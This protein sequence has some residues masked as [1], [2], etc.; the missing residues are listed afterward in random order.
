MTLQSGMPIT[1]TQSTNNNSSPASLC[2]GPISLPVRPC[3]QTNR[4]PRTSSI[5]PPLPRPRPLLSATPRAIRFEDQPF[6]DFDIA[7]VKHTHLPRMRQ[8]PRSRAEIFDIANT[9]AFAQPNGS[10]GSAAFGS[11]TSTTTDPRVVQFAIRLEADNPASKLASTHRHLWS[12]N[13]LFR[14]SP[15]SA[16]SGVMAV[17]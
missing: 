3:P 1:V 9:P 13:R 12:H 8:T 5:P 16:V 10:F 6:R 2:S 14:T 11:I 15:A 4:R 17:A 7:L